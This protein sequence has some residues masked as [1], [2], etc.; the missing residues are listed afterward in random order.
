MTTRTCSS[1]DKQKDIEE[2]SGNCNYCGK[3]TCNSCRNICNRCFEIFCN[4][5][6]NKITLWTR[7]IKEEIKICDFCKKMVEPAMKIGD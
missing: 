3:P 5:H 1:C 7:G 2:F 6:S 4:K